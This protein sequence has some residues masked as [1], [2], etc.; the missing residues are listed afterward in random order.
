[1]EEKEYDK[2]VET[3]VKRLVENNLH[4]K[5][6]KYKLKVRKVEFLGVVIRLER[7]KIEKEKMKAVL[8]KPTPKKVKNI[9]K[10][11]ELANYYR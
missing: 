10:F 5:P 3:V 8:D 1:M 11:L 6:K 2:V 4:I 7:I 9:Q